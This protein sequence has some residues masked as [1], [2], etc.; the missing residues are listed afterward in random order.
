MRIFFIIISFF[1]FNSCDKKNNVDKTYSPIK[2]ELNSKKP[3]HSGKKL[4]H[5]NCNICHNPKSTEQSRIAPP[6]I[7]IKAHYINKNTSKEE[8][9]KAFVDF[10]NNPTKEKVKLKGAFKRFGL[11]PKQNYK[12]ADLIKIADYIFDYKIDEPV[13]FKKH[14]EEKGHKMYLN[15]GKVVEETSKSKSIEEIGLEYALSTKAVLGKNLMG[16]LQKEGTLS[17][18]E[19]CNINAYPLTDSL[20]THFNV[21][22]KR[23]SDKPRNSE[24]LANTSEIKIIEHYKNVVANS[25]DI[26]PIVKKEYNKTKFYYP[27]IT[28]SMC[29]QCHGKPNNTLEKT[30]FNKIK[31]LYPLDRAIGY[32]ANQVRGIWSIAFKK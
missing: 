15:Q 24:N 12:E 7:A 30:T 31:E 26:Q 9:T 18:L 32:D 21:S 13:W 19:F 8:F 1:L 10:V 16:K 11:M 25:N 29:L 2:K 17:A 28:N 3:I 22:I 14:W 27:I 20:A 5:K 23:V 4:L 6:M